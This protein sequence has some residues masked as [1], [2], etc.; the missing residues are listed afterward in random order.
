MALF[1]IF[2]LFLGLI[3]GSFLNCVIYRLEQKKSFLKGRSFCPCCGHV[4][5]W[6]DL[7]PVFSFVFLRG[8]CCYCKEKISV[9]Y[10]LVELFAGVVFV[11]IFHLEFF[12]LAQQGLVF[13][14]ESLVSFLFL[15]FIFSS[16]IVILVYDLKHFIIPDKVLFPAVLITLF[17]NSYLFLINN[18]LFHLFLNNIYSAFGASGFFLLIILA[19]RGKWMGLGDAKLGFLMGLLLGPLNVVVALFS[20]FILGAIIGIGLIALKKKGM[21]SEVPFGPFL[22]AGTIIAMFWGQELVTWYSNLFIK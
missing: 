7:F 2:I 22:V 20:S 18:N 3:A 10:P 4:L 21:R 6:Q 9:Q 14:P 15:S 12:S 1:Y 16:L 8:R 5:R 13:S 19:S 17:Y 11:L